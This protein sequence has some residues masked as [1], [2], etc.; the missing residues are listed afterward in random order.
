[1]ASKCKKCDLIPD[2]K[3][4]SLVFNQRNWWQDGT[5]VI[6]AAWAWKL[7]TKFTSSLAISSMWFGAS[8]VALSFQTLVFLAIK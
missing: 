6:Q 4:A 3:K 2:F 8:Y 5:S 7:D 1:M